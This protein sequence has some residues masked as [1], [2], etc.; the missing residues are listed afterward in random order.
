MPLP[1]NPQN[2]NKIF[3]FIFILTFLSNT[4]SFSQNKKF[5]EQEDKLAKLYAKM[6]SFFHEDYDS[7]T[8]YSK[9]F[10][11]DLKRFIKSNPGTIKHDFKILSKD[12]NICQIQTSS[13]G[14][15]RIY[16]WD[17]ELGGTLHIFKS[18]Y[19]WKGNG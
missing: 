19:Q 4:N 16:S 5:A 17:T 13:D 10:E 6:V 7:L 15:F 1:G 9:K 11:R 14:N 18:I 8:L 12:E 3:F 2:K